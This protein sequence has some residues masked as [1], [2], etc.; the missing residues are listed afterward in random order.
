MTVNLDPSC[1]KVWCNKHK[2][3]CDFYQAHYWCCK[4]CCT[5]SFFK[6][7]TLLPFFTMCLPQYNWGKMK[8]S[9]KSSSHRCIE[10]RIYW[11]KFASGTI[12]QRKVNHP[13]PLIR[14]WRIFFMFAALV[15]WCKMVGSTNVLMNYRVK[16]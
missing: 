4:Q 15:H 11:W 5:L 10:G 12:R 3:I 14:F 7:Q 6:I 13:G 16:C 2:N 8:G 1:T 9:T